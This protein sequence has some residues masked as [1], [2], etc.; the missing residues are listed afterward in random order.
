MRYSETPAATAVPASKTAKWKTFV[1][2]LAVGFALWPWFA[3]AEW[4]WTTLLWAA[5]VL[6]VYSGAR[7]FWYATRGTRAAAPTRVG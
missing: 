5:V 7:Y 2:Q 3:D 1:Q 4:F 6:S